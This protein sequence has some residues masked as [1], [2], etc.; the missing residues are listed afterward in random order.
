MRAR[1]LETMSRAA[2]G[3]EYQVKARSRQYNGASHSCK[4]NFSWEG[5][6]GPRRE[7]ADYC[8]LIVFAPRWTTLECASLVALPGHL[9]LQRTEVA[10]SRHSQSTGS[11]ISHLWVAHDRPC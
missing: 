11:Y 1:R 6:G 4:A 3:R 8:R 7:S 2:R 5:L 10:I 9:H